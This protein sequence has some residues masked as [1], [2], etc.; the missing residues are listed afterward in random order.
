MAQQAENVFHMMG[1]IAS[2]IHGNVAHFLGSGH[3]GNCEAHL[4]CP[5]AD[6]SWTDFATEWQAAGPLDEDEY[7][8]RDAETQFTARTHALQG[9]FKQL[10][11]KDDQRL[12]IWFNNVFGNLTSGTGISSRDEGTKPDDEIPRKKSEG[13][14]NKGGRDHTNR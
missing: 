14:R 4:Q 5:L 13:I 12:R 10:G 11:Y 8:T 7:A 2:H 6:P 3:D 1:D 9:L